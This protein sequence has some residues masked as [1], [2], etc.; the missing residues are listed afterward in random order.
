MPV[1]GSSGG[2]LIQELG[3][4]KMLEK[5]TQR[6]QDTNTQMAKQ[7]AE[8]KGSKKFEKRTHKGSTHR[9]AGCLSAAVMRL[10]T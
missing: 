4:G 10:M 6:P 5:L 1:T 3:F 7:E 8:K 2:E 9:V